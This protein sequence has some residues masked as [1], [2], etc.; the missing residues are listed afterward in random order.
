M[1][2]RAA[3]RMVVCTKRFFR[4]LPVR[5]ARFEL[6]VSSGFVTLGLSTARQIIARLSI[7]F[8]RRLAFVG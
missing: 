2:P 6:L 4:I 5:S 7:A 3:E 1:A 8:D